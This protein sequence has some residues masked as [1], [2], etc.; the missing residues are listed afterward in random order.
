MG[1]V[2]TGWVPGL[3]VYIAPFLWE[4][5]ASRIETVIQQLMVA[6]AERPTSST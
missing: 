6:R 3:N 2:I 1:A 4:M 5:F